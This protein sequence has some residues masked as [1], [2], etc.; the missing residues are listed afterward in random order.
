MVKEFL[1]NSDGIKEPETEHNVIRVMVETSTEFKLN[2]LIKRTP[3][4]LQFA[5]SFVS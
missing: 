2:W 5:F 1:N 3:R 4:I